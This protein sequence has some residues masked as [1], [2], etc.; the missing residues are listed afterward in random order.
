MYECLEKLAKSIEDIEKENEFSLSGIIKTA[1]DKKK[2]L[3]A[4][5]AGAATGG[6]VFGAG[7]LYKKVSPAGKAFNLLRTTKTFPKTNPPESIF[8]ALRA[9]KGK[10]AK[11]YK[12]LFG[13]TKKAVKQKRFLIP[14]LALMSALGLG[15]SLYVKPKKQK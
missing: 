10:E 6:A 12:S 2:A 5:A 9:I 7:A 13:A 11:V 4:G 1:V 8:K 15:G 3:T 14:A